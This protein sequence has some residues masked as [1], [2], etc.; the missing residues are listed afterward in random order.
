MLTDPAN[1][2]IQVAIGVLVRER[3][4]CTEVLVT[5]RPTDTELGG[6]WEFPGGKIHADESPEACVVREFLEEVG[7]SIR[8]GRAL[9]LIEHTYDY[10]TVRLHP[11]LCA[12]GDCQVRHLEVVDHR[13]VDAAELT[14][15]DFPPANTDLVRSIQS[16]LSQQSK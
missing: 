9:P 2:I 12:D 6:Y 11:F 3:D 15:V 10:G 14:S 4:G 5:K 7:V 13:W 8:V 16:F 1:K